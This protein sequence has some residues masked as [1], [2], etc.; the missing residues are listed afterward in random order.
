MTVPGAGEQLELRGFAT[1][2]HARAAD[3]DV[4]DEILRGLEL[5][6]TSPPLWPIGDVRWEV[7]VDAVRAFADRWHVQACALGW[8]P[9]SLYGLHRRAPY[10]NLAAMGAAFVLARSGHRAVAVDAEAVHVGTTTGAQLRIYRMPPEPESVV[11]WSLCS[12][13]KC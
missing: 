6:A 2:T 3:G 8:S 7:G 13:A 10:A 9:L 5:L 1:S 4:P 12:P 11:A